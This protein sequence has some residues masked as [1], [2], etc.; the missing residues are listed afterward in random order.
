M[1]VAVQVDGV[2][3]FTHHGEGTW[4]GNPPPVG[5]VADGQD[6]GRDRG[7][8]VVVTVR[9]HVGVEKVEAPGDR[10]GVAADDMAL[11]GG[12]GDDGAGVRERVPEHVFSAGAGLRRLPWEDAS[13][14][15]AVPRAE[16]LGGDGH[17][18]EGD[19]RTRV[20]PSVVVDVGVPA[21][22]AEEVEPDDVD[23]APLLGDRGD[24]GRSLGEEALDARAGGDG[25]PGAARKLAMERRGRRAKMSAST[26]SGSSRNSP[27]AAMKREPAAGS[28]WLLFLRLPPFCYGFFFF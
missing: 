16:G 3:P 22:A 28:P 15:D 26:S 1:Q 21:G 8:Q 27:C 25:F 19:G 14:E 7:H 13:A 6:S 18:V 4:K 9:G 10:V 17:A 2:I 20:P 12:G 23:G 5:A 11:T 24:G